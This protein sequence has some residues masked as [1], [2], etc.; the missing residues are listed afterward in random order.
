VIE[1]EKARVR[2]VLIS[3][4]GAPVQRTRWRWSS[5][6][7]RGGPS[8]LESIAMDYRCA[9]RGAEIGLI[10]I[11]SIAVGESGAR[12]EGDGERAT[13]AAWRIP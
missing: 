4:S 6:P 8:A 5:R 2:H 1:K 3:S 9:E 7:I 10:A 13:R 11:D 12:G